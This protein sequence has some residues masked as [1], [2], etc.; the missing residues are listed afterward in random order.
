M[1]VIPTMRGVPAT[2]GIP[3][4]RSIKKRPR[5]GLLRR[6]RFTTA[7]TIGDLVD[8]AEAALATLPPALLSPLR[9]VGIRVE[10]FPDEEIER[11]MGLESPFDLLGLYQGVALTHKSL[12][13][14]PT[15][16][17][18]ILL[19]RRPILDEWCESGEALADLVRHVL[20]HEI[21]HHLG[22]SD[23]DMERIERE[24]EGDGDREENRS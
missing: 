1:S 2:R 20:I 16:P 19:F 17:D 24:G 9:Q 18:S 15:A 3:A 10:D 5:G 4:T 12:G 6:A 22:L 23:D 7:P 21:G 8:L 11:E 13:D 14:P